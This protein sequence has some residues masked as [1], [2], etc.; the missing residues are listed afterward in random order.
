MVQGLL[1]LV[2]SRLGHL[3]PHTKKSCLNY[4]NYI[5]KFFKLILIL[6]IT[7]LINFLNLF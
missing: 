6:K 7:F 2:K 4:K 1:L 5:F 3:N